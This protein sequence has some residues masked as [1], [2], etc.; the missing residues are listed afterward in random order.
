MIRSELTLYDMIDDCNWHFD[1][2]SALGD[3]Q[4]A[5]AKR[6]VAERWGDRPLHDVTL[7]PTQKVGTTGPKNLHRKI[8]ASLSVLKA[9]LASQKLDLPLKWQVNNT[10]PVSLAIDCYY[11]RKYPNTRTN[12]PISIYQAHMLSACL[13]QNGLNAS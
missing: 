6:F 11:V 10:R 1:S 13:L 8:Q 2:S 3:P 4:S 5:S 9:T 12:H 7:E